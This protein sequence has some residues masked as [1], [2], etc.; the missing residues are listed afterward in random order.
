VKSHS[1]IRS[2]FHNRRGGLIRVSEWLSFNIYSIKFWL[3]QV[4]YKRGDTI[5]VI[6]FSTFRNMKRNCHFN[7]IWKKKHSC[8]QEC[9]ILNSWIIC[10]SKIISG[11][12]LSIWSMTHLVGLECLM[13]LTTIFQ[14]YSGGQLYWWRK[15]E[16]PEK[17]TDLLQVTDNLYHILLYQVHLARS[18]IQTLSDWNMFHRLIGRNWTLII[19]FLMRKKFW[20]DSVKSTYNKTLLL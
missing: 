5:H 17:T 11:A 14:L 1:T 2:L 13:P 12:E 7:E 4:N 8:G 16:Y 19:F 9:H 6:K 20:I 18:G 3:S 10:N 15:P